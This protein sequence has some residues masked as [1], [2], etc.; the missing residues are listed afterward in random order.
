M[1]G[2]TMPKDDGYVYKMT[3]KRRGHFIIINN[4]KF[5]PKTN[6]P[7]RTGTDLDAARLSAAVS[8]LGFDCDILNNKTCKQMREIMQKGK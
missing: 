4:Q 7:E 5:D 1:D 8:K 6:M 3:R 2:Q